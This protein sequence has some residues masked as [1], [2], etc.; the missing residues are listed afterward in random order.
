MYGKNHHNIISNQPPIKIFKKKAGTQIPGYFEKKK[1]KYS[2][3][4][5]NYTAN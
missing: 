2:T 3:W 5:K 4:K 1:K